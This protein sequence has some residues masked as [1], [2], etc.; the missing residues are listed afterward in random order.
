MKERKSEGVI[1]SR[2]V[3]RRGNTVLK[4]VYDIGKSLR[5]RGMRGDWKV[6]K[7]DKGVKS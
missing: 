6:Q 4:I 1:L 3:T 7:R 5:G 2:R